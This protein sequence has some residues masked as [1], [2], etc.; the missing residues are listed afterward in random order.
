MIILDADVLI[1][2]FRQED[3]NHGRAVALLAAIG[4]S[5]IMSVVTLSE[6]L[7]F[8]KS[9]DGGKKTRLV[10]EKI[11]ES[12]IDI[13]EISEVME[14]IIGFVEKYDGMS[15]GDASSIALAKHLKIEKVASFDSHFDLVQGIYRIH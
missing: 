4:E 15:F 2:F 11:H 14:H 13:L 5:A 12:D 7:T 10:W 6:V 1:A 9:R 8:I 3:Q